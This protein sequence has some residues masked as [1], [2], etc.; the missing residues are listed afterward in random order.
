VKLAEGT[1]NM[2]VICKECGSTV[3]AGQSICPRC[4]SVDVVEVKSAPGAPAMGADAIAAYHTF[5]RRQRLT[6][7]AT[8]LTTI[9]LIVVF[10]VIGYL[11]RDLLPAGALLL[12]VNPIVLVI[13]GL[14][15]GFL[16]YRLWYR[17]IIGEELSPDMGVMEALTGKARKA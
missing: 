4:R 12:V 5:Q 7:V 3:P 10:G 15:A 17:R 16:S 14:A 6:F 9:A 2:A 8:I 13:L 1:T 11:V